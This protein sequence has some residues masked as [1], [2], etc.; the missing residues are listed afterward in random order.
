MTHVFEKAGLGTAPFRV[1]DLQMLRYKASPDAPSQPGAA[2]DYCGTGI[3]E[4]YFIEGSDKRR[5]KVGNECV[6]RTGDTGLIDETKKMRNAAK[7]EERVEKKARAA[8]ITLDQAKELFAM[9]EFL[10]ALPHPNEF[11]AQTKGL[12]LLDYA[13]WHLDKG[14]GRR[15]VELVQYEQSRPEDER[16]FRQQKHIDNMRIFA[17]NSAK[18]REVEEAKQIEDARKASSHYVGEV[19][20]RMKS[21]PA[22]VK[23]TCTIES[24][25]WGMPNRRLVKFVDENGNSL[26]TFSSSQSCWDVNEGDDVLITGT[27]KDHREYQGEMQTVLTRVVV[28]EK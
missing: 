13:Q 19:G 27:V 21:A 1:V 3:V 6:K 16:G 8:Q 18:Q 10:K 17:E 22:T 12:S 2:C 23:F 25:Q 28:E 7:R 5:F 20:L 11:M 15:V 26:V 24:H 14:N 4:T 9:S